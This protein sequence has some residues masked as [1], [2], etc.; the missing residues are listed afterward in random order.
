MEGQGIDPALSAEM[1]RL[2]NLVDK[3]KNISDN[4]DVVRLNVEARGSAGVLSR[5][6]GSKAG[7]TARMLPDGGLDSIETDALYAEVID[8]SED[9]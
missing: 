7:E 4:R 1:D 8:Q 5:L 2:F 9:Y 3:F 6:F